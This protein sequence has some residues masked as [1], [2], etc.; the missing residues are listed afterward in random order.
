MQVVQMMMFRVVK[1]KKKKSVE[2]THDDKANSER[3]GRSKP[4]CSCLS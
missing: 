2:A 4:D 3:C 1:E